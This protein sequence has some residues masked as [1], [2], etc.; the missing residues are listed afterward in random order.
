[1][2][3]TIRQQVTLPVTPK[4][5]YQLFLDAKEHAA[6]TDCPARISAKPGARFRVMDYIT[7]RNLALSSGKQIIQSWRGDD[8]EATD[9]DSV[10]ILNLRKVDAGVALEMIHA[11]VPE[12]HAKDLADGWK[13]FYWKPLRAYLTRPPR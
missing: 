3:T 5:L 12:G 9:P 11:G 1:M 10:L 8:W 6:F 2:P 4:R 7:G 13:T